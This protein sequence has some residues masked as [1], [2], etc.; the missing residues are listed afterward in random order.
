MSRSEDVLV[1]ASQDFAGTVTKKLLLE[2][3]HGGLKLAI[4]HAPV[5][6]DHD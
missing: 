1:V 4:E 3:A 2:L 6:N 5:S